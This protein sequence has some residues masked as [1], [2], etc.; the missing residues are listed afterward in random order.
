MLLFRTPPE[1][2]EFDRQWSEGFVSLVEKMPGIRRVAVSRVYG[3]PSEEVG[4]HLLH[5]FFFDD[6]EAMQS[7]M[8]SPEGQVAGKALMSF[9]ADLVTILFAE[10]FEEQRGEIP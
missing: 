6:R 3:A 10:H 7:A 4:Y 8:R 2:F 9:A 5:E 1:P